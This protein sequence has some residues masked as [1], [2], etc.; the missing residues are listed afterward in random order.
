MPDF[1]KKNSVSNVVLLTVLYSECQVSH[2]CTEC[3]SAKCLYAECRGAVSLRQQLPT[4]TLDPSYKTSLPTTALKAI[5]HFQ[6]WFNGDILD[7]LG[8][9][10]V[11][12]NTFFH[13][14]RIFVIS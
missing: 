6:V 8:F 3:L 1:Q 12:I 7:I 9:R 2:C 13:I 11:I 5:D 14:L 4:K 10:G